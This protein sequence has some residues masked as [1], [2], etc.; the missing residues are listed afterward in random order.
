MGILNIFIK[1]KTSIAI[2]ALVGLITAEAIPERNLIRLNTSA[3]GDDAGAAPTESEESSDE[4][5]EGLVQLK[6]EGPCVYL[7][8]TNDELDYQVDMFS[9]TFD[10]RH[11]KNA[12]AI[13]EKLGAK[14]A[15][16][17]KVHSWELY[18]KSF[19]FP[20]VRRYNF[21][22]DNMDMLEHFQDNLNT[23]VS[24]SVNMD[25]F[26]RVANTVKTN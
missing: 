4:E 24:N 22:N 26:L 9:R 23:N 11:W 18:D 17:L 1:M 20:R 15:D 14:S 12:L 5:E 13:Q 16:R 19:T 10:P 21:V 7:D 3:Y 8:E 2:L 25:R 6:T